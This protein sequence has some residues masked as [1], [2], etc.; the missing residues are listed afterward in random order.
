MD[1]RASGMI[2]HGQN[3]VRIT[4]T[5]HPPGITTIAPA[6]TIQLH[7]QGTFVFPRIDYY[8]IQPQIFTGVHYT[9]GYLAAIGDKYFI[10]QKL[11]SHLTIIDDLMSRNFYPPQAENHELLRTA[12]FVLFE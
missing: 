4:I 1:G 8:V 11:K 9:N 5:G 7:M 3:I 12:I 6:V 10:F 2:C